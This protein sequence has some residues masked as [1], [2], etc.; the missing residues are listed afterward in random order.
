M[1]KYCSKNLTIESQ[2]YLVFVEVEKFF[3][4]L[5][6]FLDVLSQ[7]DLPKLN[8]ESSSNI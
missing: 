2:R 5:G 1:N 4:V 7:Q 8:Y 6:A 3:V